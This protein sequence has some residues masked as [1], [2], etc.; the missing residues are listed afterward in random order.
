MTAPINPIPL[1]NT[2][3][4]LTDQVLATYQNFY[5]LPERLTA[6]DDK[7]IYIDPS[8]NVFHLNGSQAGAEGV[9][10]GE[11]LQGEQHFP[12]EQIITEGAYQFGATIERTNYPKRLI[13]LRVTIGGENFTNY[14]YEM[15]DNRW[16][17]GQ[18]ET[19]DGWLGIGTRFTGWRWIPVR[20]FKTIDTAQKRSPKAYGNNM[21]TWDINWVCQRPYYS[22]PA[23]FQ[24]WFASQSGQPNAAGMYTGSVKLA[25]RG[26]LPTTVEY[27]I[28]GA[29]VATVQDNNSTNMVTLPPLFEADGVGLC[30]T[31]PENRT[32]TAANDPQD[33]AFFNWLAGSEIL[34]FLLTN[35]TSSSDPWWER[36]YVR[37]LYSV[38]P[39]TVVT[40]NVAHTNPNAVITAI[41]PQRYKRSR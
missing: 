15:C 4:W 9:T 31:D 27:L 19:R 8:G 17:A 3:P 7:V 36:G 34:N 37:F 21:A 23:V 2:A 40:F 35:V 1:G 12:F 14:Q 41:L 30:D 24:T 33:N 32:L 11:Q 25:N 16:W 13:N 5:N 6:L 29:G 26:D 22:K 28:D 18:D 10:L 20:P 38:P 39:Q